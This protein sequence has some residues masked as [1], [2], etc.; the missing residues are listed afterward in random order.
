MEERDLYQLLLE[1][2]KRWSATINAETTR[3]QRW[4]IFRKFL[5]ANGKYKTKLLEANIAQHEPDYGNLAATRE[6]CARYKSLDCR[7]RSSIPR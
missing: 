6:D 1:V 2:D 5:Y 4:D 7:I 3:V